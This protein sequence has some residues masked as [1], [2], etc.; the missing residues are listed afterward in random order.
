MN[1]RRK[2]LVAL[3]ASTIAVPRLSFG[4]QPGRIGRIGFLSPSPTDNDPQFE[5]F[6]QQLR[7]LGHV[8]GKTITINYL[9]AEGK[10]DRLPALACCDDRVHPTG[11][12]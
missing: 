4:Q 6:K 10:Y 8:E 11:F 12:R 9:S 3:G 2:L 7:D 1:N 5:A